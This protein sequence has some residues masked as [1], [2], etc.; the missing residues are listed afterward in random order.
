M[1]DF[2]LSDSQK[3]QQE[4]ARAFAQKVLKG[5]NAMYSKRP[6][7]KERFRSTRSFYRIAVA[8]GQIKGQILIPLGGACA[9]LIDAAIILEELFTTDASVTLTVA[10]TGLG[11]TPLIMSGNSKLQKK[12]LE[13][14]LKNEG[15]PLASLV[16]SEP[17]GTANWL[18]KGAPGLQTTAKK[19]GSHWVINGEKA[20]Q[21]SCPLYNLL[22]LANTLIGLDSKQR[23]MGWQRQW[24]SRT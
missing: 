15:G 12:F 5:A 22:L 21:V 13:P 14:F 3:Q 6:D 9:S 20:C 24:V 18:E 7:Q 8:G 11:L 2:T 17:Q 16:Q 23:R 4:G 19:D 1:I 10:A